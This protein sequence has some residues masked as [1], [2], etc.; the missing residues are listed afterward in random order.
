MAELDPAAVTERVLRL[1][2]ARPFDSIPA[3]ELAQ[4][5]SAG[6]EV[7]CSTRTTLVA[8]GERA[9]AHWVALTGRLRAVRPAGAAFPGDRIENGFGGL[10]ILGDRP[11]PCD[12]VAEPG[13]VLLVLDADALFAVLDES[14]GLTRSLLRAMAQAIIDFRT[15]AGRSLP[16]VPPGA[17][18]APEALD[19]L[20][21]V[22]VL[23]EAIGL[24]SRSL[25]VLVRLARAARVE[26]TVARAAL[27]DPGLTPADLVIVPERQNGTSTSSVAGRAYGLVE[28]VAGVA[29]G[30]VATASQETTRLVVA[31]PEIQE[32]IEDDDRFCLELVRLFARELWEEFWGTPV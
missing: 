23:R 15:R 22:V 2:H 17:S 25:P 21:R 10:S 32:V 16:D 28:S 8:E 6:R 11:M 26:R 12:L 30:R 24:S 31:A 9:S 18:I 29:M 5:A 7:V 14:G 13:S 4:F 20:A 27:W 3:S 19:V 1:K